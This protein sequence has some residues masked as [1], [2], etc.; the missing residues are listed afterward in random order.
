M[1]P[2]GVLRP[3]TTTGTPQTCAQHDEQDQTNNTLS[4]EISPECNGLAPQFLQHQTAT[5]VSLLQ[6]LAPALMLQDANRLHVRPS[7]HETPVDNSTM[8]QPALT[9]R[10]VQGRP[11]L[12]GAVPTH[13][14]C[15][16]C[17]EQL[18][19]KYLRCLHLLIHKLTLK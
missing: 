8:P 17:R 14:H 18:R 5:A 9:R 16:V 10:T 1:H 13:I 19:F 15:G 6:C 2:A 7:Y 12:F 11:A 4:V 3:A